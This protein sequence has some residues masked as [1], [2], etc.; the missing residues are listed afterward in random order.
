LDKY[1]YFL[2]PDLMT[3]KGG[4]MFKHLISYLDGRTTS[5]QPEGWDRGSAPQD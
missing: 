4:K 5:P 2:I 1:S 3:E